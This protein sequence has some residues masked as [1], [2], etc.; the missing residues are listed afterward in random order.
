MT[1]TRSTVPPAAPR[2]RRMTAVPMSAELVYQ[3]F[4]SREDA[5]Q[6]IK[7]RDGL[8]TTLKE[9]TDAQRRAVFLALALAGAFALIS[10]GTLV[11]VA[12]GPFAISDLSVVQK[13]L[14]AVFAY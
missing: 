14:P 10:T 9:I 8:R 2:S 7:Y 1:A 6:A 3:A 13:A 12:L 4:P 5:D 11:H